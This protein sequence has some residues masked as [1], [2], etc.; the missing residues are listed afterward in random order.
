MEENEREGGGGGGRWE[1][2]GGSEKTRKK[3]KIIWKQAQ[4]RKRKSETR[5]KTLG[6]E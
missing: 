3:E 1:R 5:N 2:G 6:A 4:I